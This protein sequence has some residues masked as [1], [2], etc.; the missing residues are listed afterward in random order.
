MELEECY[1]GSTS[2]GLRPPTVTRV[3]PEGRLGMR[4]IV[5][6]EVA[7]SFYSLYAKLLTID[8]R[9]VEKMRAHWSHWQGG[10]P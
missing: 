8:Y 9:Q 6:Y 2:Q 7:L 3:V 1:D 4:A 10:E 5:R